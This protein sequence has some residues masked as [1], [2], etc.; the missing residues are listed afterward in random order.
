MKTTGVE[1]IITRCREEG[2]RF[3]VAHAG[4]TQGKGSC[5]ALSIV[6]HTTLKTFQRMSIFSEFRGGARVG[7]VVVVESDSYGS[8]R[9]C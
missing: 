2:G 6:Q 7:N 1:Q 4:K 3:N 9:Q 8:N 5:K